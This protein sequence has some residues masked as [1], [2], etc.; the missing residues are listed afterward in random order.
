[1]PSPGVAN[2]IKILIHGTSWLAPVES[3][4]VWLPT[5]I[6]VGSVV[7]VPGQLK[8]LIRNETAPRAP[9]Q[10]LF[11]KDEISL[12][13]SFDRLERAIP[14]FNGRAEVDIQYPLILE[15]PKVLLSVAKGDIVRFHWVVCF[16]LVAK[17]RD[18]DWY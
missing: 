6:P 11:V 12:I 3:E 15:P 18:S 10:Q 2:P 13:A 7:E 17:T 1:M 4:P 16:A 14:E 9:G 8:C 5:N